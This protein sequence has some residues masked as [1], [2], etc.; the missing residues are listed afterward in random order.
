[1]GGGFYRSLNPYNLNR[2]GVSNATDAGEFFEGESKVFWIN[3]VDSDKSAVKIDHARYAYYREGTGE[4]SIVDGPRLRMTQ[5]LLGAPVVPV[6]VH[7]RL[8]GRDRAYGTPFQVLICADG[9][10]TYDREVISDGSLTLPVPVGVNVTV[11]IDAPQYLAT[12]ILIASAMPPRTLDVLLRCGDVN[13]DGI[14]DDADLARPADINL[15]GW[16]N[17]KDLS[18]IK[19]NLGLVEEAPACEPYVINGVNY[20][21]VFSQ[22]ASVYRDAGLDPESL[23]PDAVGRPADN[24]IAVQLRKVVEPCAAN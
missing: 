6:V 5:P 16:I 10:V 8:E 7:V 9:Q 22:K 1:M 18:L 4:F 2:L 21:V 13:D 11:R 23:F 19:M 24:A 17:S 12:N 15:D 20:E 3:P 14:I